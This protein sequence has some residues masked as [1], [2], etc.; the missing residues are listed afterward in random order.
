MATTKEE[1]YT[2]MLETLVE[3]NIHNNTPL[4]NEKLRQ[5]VIK[6]MAENEEEERDAERNVNIVTVDNFCH[7]SPVKTNT[8]GEI[9]NITN[10]RRIS[11]DILEK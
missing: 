1:Y 11:L 10:E 8:Q 4:S 5:A 6:V 3:Y 2:K 9:S 7:Q